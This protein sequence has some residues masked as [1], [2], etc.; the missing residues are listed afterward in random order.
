MLRYTSYFDFHLCFLLQTIYENI[1]VKY[2]NEAAWPVVDRTM[3][4]LTIK[5]LKIEHVLTCTRSPQRRKLRTRSERKR[6][7][8]THLQ[9]TPQ[10]YLQLLP[11]MRRRTMRGQRPRRKVK[12]RR[13]F[14]SHLQQRPPPRPLSKRALKLP[15]KLRSRRHPSPHPSESSVTMT[16]SHHIYS[17]T[18]LH[19]ANHRYVCDMRINANESVCT[20]CTVPAYVKHL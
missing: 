1:C 6:H 14:T 18:T 12:F 4:Y 7:L 20:K 3:F 8:Q 16:S 19:S 9:R 11:Q 13:N 15:P 17:S 5:Y 10:L 2:V